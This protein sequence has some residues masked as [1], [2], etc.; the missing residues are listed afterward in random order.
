MN[1]APLIDDC[2]QQLARIISY[3]NY[4]EIWSI[5]LEMGNEKLEKVV[6]DFVV[7]QRFF[8]YF[9]DIPQDLLAKV[10]TS[11]E[12]YKEKRGQFKSM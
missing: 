5:A 4:L 2:C 6:V 8:H 7:N 3:S 1:F 11:I 12:L 9:T 10:K